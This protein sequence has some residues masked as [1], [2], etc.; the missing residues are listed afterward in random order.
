MFDRQ[1]F[2]DGK[3]RAVRKTASYSLQVNDRLVVDS[4]ST[5]CTF[6]L[7]PVTECRGHIV[8]FRND[9]A[10]TVAVQDNDDSTGWSDLSATKAASKLVLYCDGE[11]WH[12]LVSSNFT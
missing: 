3:S 11:S 6:T 10:G 2:E 5:S 9:V 7:P 1:F 12:N 8:S 4:T